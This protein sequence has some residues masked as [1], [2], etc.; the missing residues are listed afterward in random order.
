M[1]RFDIHIDDG[2]LI[3]SGVGCN[4]PDM[5][6]AVAATVQAATLKA[7]ERASWGYPRQRLV[8][9]VL[10]HGT[11]HRRDF[12]VIYQASRLRR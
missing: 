6:A 4:F 12:D 9:E 1:P 5:D 2:D 11:K 7:E 3:G 10:E 8:C